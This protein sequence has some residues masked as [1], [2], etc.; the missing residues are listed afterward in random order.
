[1]G[2]LTH[3][4]VIII[5]LCWAG[6][7]R[8]LSC[9][10][11]G[12]PPRDPHRRSR[13]LSFPQQYSPSRQ[14]CADASAPARQGGMTSEHAASEVTVLLWGSRGQYR[15]GPWPTVAHPTTDLPWSAHPRPRELPHRGASRTAVQYRRRPPLAAMRALRANLGCWISKCVRGDGGRP[16][17]VPL[18]QGQAYCKMSVPARVVLSPQY[19]V[20]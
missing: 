8:S 19:L 16:G 11:A 6:M 12:C 3:E 2:V 10:L 4:L 5:Y 13:H 1:M 18:A 7:M 9:R 14:D 15:G 20:N 17:G